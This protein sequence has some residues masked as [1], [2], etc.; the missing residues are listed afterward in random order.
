MQLLAPHHRV[1]GVGVGDVFDV[2]EQVIQ[3]AQELQEAG[4]RRV[5]DFIQQL[6]AIQLDLLEQREEAQRLNQPTLVNAI[7]RLRGQVRTVKDWLYTVIDTY[8]GGIEV[9]DRGGSPLS[10]AIRAAEE[11]VRRR[12]AGA[13]SMSGYQGLGIPALAWPT[14]VGIAVISV[15]ALTAVISYFSAQKDR[16]KRILETCKT[17]P[18]ACPDA[19]R[20]ARDVGRGVFGEAADVLQNVLYVGLFGVAAWVAWKVYEDAKS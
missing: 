10:R 9:L 14:V 17:N 20:A 4:A 6:L 18:A 2:P 19:V 5:H 15:S 3:F 8:L 13:P 16:T 12:E 7:E 11:Y 1:Q